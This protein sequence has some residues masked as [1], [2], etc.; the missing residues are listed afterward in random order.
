MGIDQSITQ[1]ANTMDLS[2][3]EVREAFDKLINTP[4]SYVPIQGVC[5]STKCSE[6]D[7]VIRKKMRRFYRKKVRDKW[8]KS[9][10]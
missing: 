7:A 10:K 2:E 3:A 8:I 5:K 1:I 9:G 4:Q 6:Y